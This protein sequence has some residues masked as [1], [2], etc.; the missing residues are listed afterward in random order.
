IA[1]AQVNLAFL[2]M[3]GKGVLKDNGRALMW[4]EI[5]RRSG[6][7][8]PTAILDSLK[9]KMSPGE[10]ESAIQMALNRKTQIKKSN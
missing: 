4:L 7:A 10:V 8:V 5:A 9:A 1:P 6:I 2:Y 3:Q